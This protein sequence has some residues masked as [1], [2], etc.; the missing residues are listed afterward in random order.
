MVGSAWPRSRSAPASRTKAIF[1][2]SLSGS[3]AS[4]RGSFRLSQ[5]S[6]KRPQVRQ[7][8]GSPG[9]ASLL[10][11]RDAYQGNRVTGI[12]FSIHV[13]TF[14]RPYRLL[15]PKAFFL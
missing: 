3:L 15:S 8:L 5:A 2:F 7:E 1:A 6:P 9:L 12:S 4:R 11:E 14:P 10:L 13:V